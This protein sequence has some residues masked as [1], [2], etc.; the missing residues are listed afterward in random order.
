VRIQVR[1]SVEVYQRVQAVAREEGKTCGRVAAEAI[2]FYLYFR[3]DV[4]GRV[5]V[6]RSIAA[7]VV[8]KRGDLILTFSE[9]LSLR[10]RPEEVSEWFGDVSDCQIVEKGQVLKLIRSDGTAHGY[11]ADFMADLSDPGVREKSDE[12]S[13]QRK[14]S[15]SR[16]I[17]AARRRKNL[18]AKRLAQASGVTLATL[19]AVERCEIEVDRKTLEALADALGVPAD[20][21]DVEEL[22]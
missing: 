17:R 1:V 22:P 2:E 6:E 3:T 4:D 5:Q 18:S 20:K 16:Q 7:A 11:G 19:K 21:L 9:G 14:L 15:V 10:M 13:A 8:T 12:E